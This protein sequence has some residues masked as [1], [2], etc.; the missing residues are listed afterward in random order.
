MSNVGTVQEIWRHPVKSMGGESLEA[1]SFT[2]E[3]LEGDRRWGVVDL[4]TGKVLSAKRY[5]KLLEARATL[6]EGADA[7]TVELP[8]GATFEAGDPQLDDALG[9][10]LGRV[11]ALRPA[12][13]GEQSQYDFKLSEFGVDLGVPDEETQVDTPAGTFYD[14]ANAHLLTT[15]SLA[16]GEAT[17]PDGVWDVR[18]FR[19]QLLID[20]GDLEGFIENDWVGG[21][22]STGEAEFSP[23]MPTVRCVMPTRTQPG[24]GRDKEIAQVLQRVN[25]SN[26]G[27]YAAVATP[28][29]VSIGDPVHVTA[30]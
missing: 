16:A 11:V 2:N 1:T 29:R 22:I 17:H 12:P 24:L 14:L 7:P 3:G 8:S 10:W 15:A 6:A 25:G 23:F 28:G 20:T 4:E 30:G 5:G 21:R 18:R 9:D 13:T 27:V 19:P 26:L